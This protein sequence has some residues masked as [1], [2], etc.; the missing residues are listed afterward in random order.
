MQPGKMQITR[1]ILVETGTYNDM[2]IRPYQ[3]N[4]NDTTLNAMTEATQGGRRLNASV[5]AGVAGSIIRPSSMAVGA[6]SIDNG[7]D[8][9]RFRFLM[10]VEFTDFNGGTTV[11]YVSG[12]TD[13]ADTSL[14]SQQL[15]PRMMLHINNVVK[16]RRVTEHTPMGLVQRTTVAEAAQILT[17]NYNPQFGGVTNAAQTMRPEDV[18]GSIGAQVLGADAFDL[19]NTFAGGAKKSNRLNGAATTY[20]SRIMTSH[21]TAMKQA[22]YA[23]DPTVMADNAAGLAREGLIANDPFLSA[24]QR[25]TNFQGGTSVAYGQLCAMSPSLDNIAQV[26]MAR[27]VQQVGWQNHLRGQSEH[28]TGTTNETVFATILAHSVPS[29]MM[30]LMLTQITIS[31]TNRTLDGSFQSQ[32]LAPPESFAQGMDL[33]PYLDLFNR[34]F[35]SEVLR[36]LT[37]NNMIDIS[38]VL[39]VDVLGDTVIDIALMGG[40]ETRYVVPSFCDALMAPVITNSAMNVQSLASDISALADALEQ[41]Y[42]P[43]N[44]STN[45]GLFHGHSTTV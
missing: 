29:I 24:L 13:H 5:L 32:F 12:Y 17:G 20:L 37:Q 25:H 1:F 34:R 27:G 8:T 26:I 22:G 21:Q 10:E 43:E 44:T 7:W 15:D 41:S 40:P 6:V 14:Q 45:F 28:W 39:H 18:F 9:R 31:V 23:D 35:E 30:D 16:A 19:R 2:A 33:S 42:S 36:D 4:I 3:T 11:E 38:L